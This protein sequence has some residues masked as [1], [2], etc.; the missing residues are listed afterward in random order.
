MAYNNLAS[1]TPS[2]PAPA[3]PPSRNAPP[4]SS[5]APLRTNGNFP[6]SSSSRSTSNGNSNGNAFSSTAYAPSFPSTN[7]SS[8]SLNS[9]GSGGGRDSGTMSM[10]TGPASVKEEGLRS[11]LW[12]KRWLVL[13]GSELQIFK[14]E[15]CSI[16][17]LLSL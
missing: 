2:R 10:R 14:N 11:F 8:L 17:P 1:L 16:S 5:F 9:A 15:V 4:S 7:P 12:S 3:P 6:A 13:G